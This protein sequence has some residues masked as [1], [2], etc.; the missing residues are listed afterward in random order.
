VD[1]VEVLSWW[2]DQ[3]ESWDRRGDAMRVRPHCS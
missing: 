3:V 1:E 2:I